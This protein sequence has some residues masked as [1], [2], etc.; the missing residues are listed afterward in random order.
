MFENGFPR[1]WSTIKKLAWLFRSVINAVIPVEKTIT[2]NPIH[3]TDAL[4]KPVQALSISLEPIQDLNGYDNPWPSGGG[5]N[6]FDIAAS[7]TE[8]EVITN[9]G[10]TATFSKGY[11]KVTGTNTSGSGFNIV[12]KN[13]SGTLGA[14]KYNFAEHLTIRCSVDGGANANYNWNVT[15]TASVSLVAFY[16]PVSASASNIDWNIPM[17]MVEETASTSTYYPYSNICPISGH[18]D[19]NVVRTGKNLL[20]ASNCVDNL[21]INVNSN[22]FQTISGASVFYAY[23]K[24]NTTY[25]VSC[26]KGDRTVIAS[27]NA[28]PANNVSLKRVIVNYATLSVPQT[29]TTQSDETLICFYFNRYA[30]TKPTQPQLELGETAHDFAPYVGTTYPIPL[31]QTVYGGTL[32]VATGVLTIT[33]AFAQFD[34]T[35]NWNQ[36]AQYC[37]VFGYPQSYSQ[38]GSTQIGSHF[39]TQFV[40]NAGNSLFAQQNGA[41]VKSNRADR[42]AW[43]AELAQQAA[44]GTPVQLCYELATPVT[45]QLTPTQVE[46]LL[47]ENNIWSDGEMTLVYLADG[48]ASDIEALNILL[49]GR[50]VNNHTEDEPTDREALDILLGGNR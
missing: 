1:E 47:G 43:K 8:G 9:S 17:Q 29:F 12:Y 44:D 41:V 38:G 3:I 31:G 22:I 35:E 40:Y 25:T 24:P 5:K 10:I 16:V 42:D 13:I 39:S 36:T 19:A 6:K 46:L 28:L 20:D 4:A 48:N 23:V 34:G 45:I 27:A 26:D 33:H 14:G 15:A 37:Y 49:G 30:E 32:D 21:F 7:F 50:Y 11:L 2:G 18:T